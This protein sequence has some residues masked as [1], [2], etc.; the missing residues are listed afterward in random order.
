MEFILKLHLLGG[1]LVHLSLLLQKR[2][3]LGQGLLL[4]SKFIE[5]SLLVG[6]FGI[7]DFLS[8]LYGSLKL[9]LHDSLAFL[10]L[11][12]D[13]GELFVELINGLLLAFDCHGLCVGLVALL[14]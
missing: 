5:L 13:I 2:V 11:L 3:R 14:E 7:T 8:V 12:S 1:E 4:V 6:S 10:H 9:L